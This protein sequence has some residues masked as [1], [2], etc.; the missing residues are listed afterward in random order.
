MKRLRRRRHGLRMVVVGADD[1][2]P[3]GGVKSLR[4]KLLHGEIC[5]RQVAGMRRISLWRA[6]DIRPYGGVKS[7]QPR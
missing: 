1:I 6:D 5:L 3:Y 2:R 7:L 4:N